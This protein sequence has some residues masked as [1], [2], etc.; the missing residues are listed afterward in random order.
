MSINLPGS[1]EYFRAMLFAGEEAEAAFFAGIFF[2]AD[3]FA[4]AF[5]EADFLDGFLAIT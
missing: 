3:F 2:E 4:E 1:Q 5:F